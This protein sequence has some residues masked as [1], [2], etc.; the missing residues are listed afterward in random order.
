MKKLLLVGALLGVL[1]PQVAGAQNPGPPPEGRRQMLQGQIVQ[2]FMDHV[3]NELQLDQSARGKLEQVLRQSG[4]SRRDLARSTAQLRGRMMAAAR[5]SSTTD[6]EFKKLL[7]EMTALR[8]REE[9]LWT[10]DQEALARILTPRQ[11]TRF[12][13]MWL[14]FNEQ[15]RE[16][17]LRPPP[18]APRF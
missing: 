5:D 10:K 6:A 15:I 3:T 8:Q 1:L 9:D 2:R 16:M 12:V 14:R 13:F 7:S 17:A 4:E 11:Q 18:G